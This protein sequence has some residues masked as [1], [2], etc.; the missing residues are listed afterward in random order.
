M[1]A[2]ALTALR[3]FR[4]RFRHFS[5]HNKRGMAE[6]I[7]Q[8]LQCRLTANFTDRL[9]DFTL[10]KR[11]Y[12]AS[13]DLHQG[14]KRTM[15]SGFAQQVHRSHSRLWFRVGKRAHELHRERLLVPTGNWRA[16]MGARLL[17]A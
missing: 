15:E 1:R 8:Q 3:I 10:E 9:N 5:P 2:F 11:I 7:V 17:V 14:S 13:V 6:R 12:R 16:A 4:E